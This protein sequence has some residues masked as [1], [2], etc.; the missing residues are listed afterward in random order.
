M[1]SLDFKDTGNI[2]FYKLG[3]GYM[4]ALFI[5]FLYTV[6]SLHVYFTVKIKVNKKKEGKIKIFR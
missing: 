2:L 5:M 3:S 1:I 4:N 6:Y